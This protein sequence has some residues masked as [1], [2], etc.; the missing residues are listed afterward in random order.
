MVIRRFIHDILYFFLLSYSSSSYVLH[1]Y[2][3]LCLM[4]EIN[5]ED[6]DDRQQTH[7]D[8]E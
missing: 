4:Y 1:F 3:F 5:T 8:E 2:V 7:D 6:E